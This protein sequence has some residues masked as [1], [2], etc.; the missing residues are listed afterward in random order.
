MLRKNSISGFANLYLKQFA[1]ETK[2]YDELEVEIYEKLV[3][4]DSQ[5][6][7][8]ASEQLKQCLEYTARYFIIKV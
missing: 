6:G 2:S 8:T 3:E 5:L 1:E 4:L 7:T